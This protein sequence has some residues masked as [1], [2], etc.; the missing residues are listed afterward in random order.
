VIDQAFNPFIPPLL[1]E[2]GYESISC[3]QALGRRGWSEVRE[4]FIGIRE[5]WAPWR[6]ILEYLSFVE[7]ARVRLKALPTGKAIGGLHLLSARYESVA[8]IFFAQATLDQ[9][10]VWLTQ[11]MKLKV[12]GSKR[13]LHKKE[14]RSALSVSGSKGAGIA[15]SLDRYAQY[16]LELEQFRQIWIHSLPGG[17]NGFMDR[18]PDQGGIPEIAV[19]IDP[20]IAEVPQ[21]KYYEQVQRCREQNGGRWLYPIA[22]FADRFAEG[23]KSLTLSVLDGATN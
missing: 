21:A 18:A 14:F 1:R 4:N 5:K 13:Q 19:P 12:A 22:E 7:L 17:A 11:D 23:T 10:A 8:L 15:A 9:V 16:L 20:T 6:G 3:I 2:L